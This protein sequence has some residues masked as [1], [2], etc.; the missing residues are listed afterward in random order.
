MDEPEEG[1][2]VAVA[3][4]A[5]EDSAGGEWLDDGDGAGVEAGVSDGAG[6]AL[7]LGCP[8]QRHPPEGQC[9]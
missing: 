5:A 7:S 4:G 9:P 1:L 8:G 2:A 3:T 6:V